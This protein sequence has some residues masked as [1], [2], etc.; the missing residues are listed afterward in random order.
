MFLSDFPPITQYFHN[1]SVIAE[2]IKLKITGET[3]NY[4]TLLNTEADGKK[5]C[6]ERS[7]S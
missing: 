5:T 2:K 4:G 7:I 1:T 6:F 3:Q